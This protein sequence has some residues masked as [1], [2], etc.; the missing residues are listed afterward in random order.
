MR[1]MG[2]QDSP[3]SRAILRHTRLHRASENLGHQSPH[4]LPLESS[5][6]Q[7]LPRAGLVG[8]S[9]PPTPPPPSLA[10][11]PALAP[12]PR[13]AQSGLASH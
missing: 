13:G 12:Q 9:P 3:P 10:P 7:P 1:N 8:F 5:R 2:L 11:Q 4:W 6:L